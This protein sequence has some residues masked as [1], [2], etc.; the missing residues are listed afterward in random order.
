VLLGGNPDK[1]KDLMHIEMQFRNEG[2]KDFL[3]RLIAQQIEATGA[4]GYVMINE[5][6]LL[7]REQFPDGKIPCN[8]L[9]SEHPKRQEVIWVALFTHDYHKGRAAI[10]ERKGFSIQ[11]IGEIPMEPDTGIQGRFANLLPPLN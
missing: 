6:W 11:F 5:A 3:A 2:D 4:W 7:S 9:P 10:F 1:V 8:Q